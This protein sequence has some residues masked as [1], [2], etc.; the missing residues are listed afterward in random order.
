MIVPAGKRRQMESQS[1][2]WNEHEGQVD[3]IIENMLRKAAALDI[4]PSEAAGNLA[5]P[6]PQVEPGGQPDTVPGQTNDIA[7][8]MDQS[9]TLPQS[10]DQEQIM[11]VNKDGQPRQDQQGQVTKQILEMLLKSK[12]ADPGTYV[13]TNF[14]LSNGIQLNAVRQAANVGPAVQKP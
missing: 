5:A 14:D 10:N 4:A 7:N 3:G 2:L 9:T 1:Y 11:V 6:K 12:L 13:L 8:A